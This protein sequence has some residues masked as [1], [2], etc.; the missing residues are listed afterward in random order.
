MRRLS[1]VV[2]IAFAT[3][4]SLSICSAQQTATTSVPNLIRYSGTLKDAQGAAPSS[5]TAVGF[6][7]SIYKQQDG[8]ASVWMETQNVT[9]DANGQYNVILGS[10]TAAGLPGDLF[11]QQEQRWLGVQVQGQEEQARVLLVSVPYALKAHE[12]DTLGGMP[13]SAIIKAATLAT[14]AALANGTSVNA[15]SNVGNP[16]GARG[17][18]GKLPP[19]GC[20]EVSGWITYWNING[21]LCQSNIFQV[22][23]PSNPY[24]GNI[25]IGTQ[26]PSTA[27]DVFGAIDVSPTTVANSST[28]NYQILENPVLGIGYPAKYVIPANENTY[29]GL[30]AGGQGST[31]LTD[32]G[33]LNTFVGYNAF[34]HNQ[35]GSQNTGVGVGAGFRNDAG[36]KN[37]YVGFDSGWTN[38]GNINNNTFTGWESGFANSGS[39][40]VFSGYQAGSANTA[41][42]D[43]FVGYQAGLNNAGGGFNTFVGSD[44]GVSNNTGGAN[45]YVGRYAGYSNASGVSNTMLGA[46]AGF[47]NTGG[48]NTFVGSSAGQMHANGNGNTMVGNSAGLHGATG[49]SNS[50]F[51]N[52]AG[53]NNTGDNNTFV[54]F[55]AGNANTA[56]GNSF[57]G[58]DAGLSNAAG[59][60]NTFVG[61]NA[62][63]DN[64]AGSGN[65]YVGWKA[66]IHGAP[67]AGTCCNTFVGNGAGFGT[68]AGGLT[69]AGNSYLGHRAGEATTTGGK[70]AFYGYWSGLV[71]TNGSFNAFYGDQS[72]QNNVGG[73]YN[74]YLGAAADSGGNAGNNNIHVGYQAGNA[75]ANGGNNIEIG[76]LGTGGDAGYI[77]IGTE[78]SQT[79]NTYIAGIV[80][81]PFSPTPLT[82]V[83]VD[84]VTNKGHLGYATITSGGGNVI[85]PTNPPCNA[86]LLTVWEGGLDVGCSVVY[87]QPSTNYI[88]IGTNFP[89]TPLEVGG[90]ITADTRY[91]IT[92]Q[93]FPVLSIDNPPITTLSQYDANLFVGIGAGNANVSSYANSVGIV[94]TFVGHNAGHS[95]KGNNL[96]TY[97]GSF[98]NFFGEEAGYQNTTGYYN[99]FVGGEAGYGNTDSTENTYV[100]YSTGVGNNAPYNTFVGT[101]A[102]RVV[103]GASSNTFVGYK[104]AYWLGTGAGNIFL[105]SQ[106]GYNNGGATGS[107]NDIYIGSLGCTFLFC[108]ESNTIRIGG[109]NN[110]PQ[111]ATYIAGIGGSTMGTVGPPQ[112]VCV[113]GDGKLWGQGSTP[114]ILSSRRFK[115]QI[116]E[117]G[118]SSSKLLQLRPVNFFYK[119]EYDDGSHQLQYGLIAEEVAKVYPEMVMY[120]KDGQP[121]TVKYQLLAPML[122]NEL[123]KQHTVVTA[124]QDEL[125]TQLQQIKAQRQ[126]IDGLKH[127]LQLQ[128]ASLQERLT[129]L[130]SYVA[131]QTQMKTASDNPPRT[132]PV[133]DGGSQ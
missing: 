29:V 50:F 110:G 93:E 45:T 43:V 88:G 53:D 106:A 69:G 73:N 8:G 76:N 35:A 12:A 87:Q 4:L 42:N 113:G 126:E 84:T 127:E 34:F 1:A 25:G 125:Q 75:T 52:G 17:K 108:N 116:T 90:E 98:N 41:S 105:G 27:F 58:Y 118:D 65:T 107:T 70:N 130:E 99:T 24:F 119:P 94:N 11:S 129:K 21:A 13:A 14:S 86:N 20:L 121:Y 124:Q 68:G 3:L 96:V 36:N 47:S 15:L 133:A 115:E 97:T 92:T 54:G 95:N 61:L 46:N 63:N 22:F 100:G 78:P 114:C 112:V 5:S 18:D 74:T 51:G 10:T 60:Q 101:W 104:T 33:T 128:N 122:L 102:G 111:T 81:N 19:N 132:T 57:F 117:M 44:T 120:G 23:N 64:V 109:N 62:G 7:F 59:N 37:T 48:F 66:G 2:A 16:A 28:G 30:L 79:M 32:I 40:N 26:N 72:G 9:P 89:S 83:T 123:Q 38:S 67:G 85:G 91:D 55:D 77:R 82:V 39:N 71:N 31:N 103:S 56:T 49:A 131:T 6:T 80:S